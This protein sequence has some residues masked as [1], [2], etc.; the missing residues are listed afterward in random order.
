MTVSGVWARWLEITENNTDV[1][2]EIDLPQ[3]SRI[4]A[5]V[6]LSTV[7]VGPTIGSFDVAAFVESYTVHEPGHPP[8]VFTPQQ[9]APPLLVLNNVVSVKFRLFTAAGESPP[10]ARAVCQVSP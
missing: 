6:Q 4:V 9:P 2:A 1:T 7:A 5:C 10:T 8:G 3:P